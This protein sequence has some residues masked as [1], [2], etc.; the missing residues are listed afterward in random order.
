MSDTLTILVKPDGPIKVT[1]AQSARFCGEALEFD[2]ALFLCRCGESPKAPFCDGTHK[3]VGFCGTSE[4]PPSAPVR[5]WEG[6]TLR[7]FFNPNACMHVF[8]CKPMKGLRA[9]EEAGDASAAA[10]IMTVV[11]S[12][13]SGAL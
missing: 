9:R 11:A 5:V 12:C 6:Q 10:E 7:T 4:E 13:P 3:R 1:G 8:Y 2:G